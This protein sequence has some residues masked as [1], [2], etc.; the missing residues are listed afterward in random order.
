MKALIVFLSCWLPI[1]T[2]SKNETLFG[3]TTT[4]SIS[5]DYP[6]TTSEQGSNVHQLHRKIPLY[7]GGFFSLGGVWDGSGI[8]PA[9]EMALDHINDRMDILPNYDLRMTWNDTQCE[10][11]LGTRTLFD[12]IFHEPQ[13][14]AILGPPCS[15]D[16]EAIADVAHY[17]N[18][19]TISYSAA[20]PDLANKKKYPLFSRTTINSLSYNPSRVLTIKEFKWK[21]VGLIQENLELFSLERSQGSQ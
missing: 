19:I 13:K 8:L 11:G 16:A 1:L 12:Q 21:R 15:T 10:S 6:V 17:W 9:V 7:L 5:V 3:T 14:I 2:A 4:S 20:S 18:L